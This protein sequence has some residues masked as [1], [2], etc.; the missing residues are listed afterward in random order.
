MAC[1][2]RMGILNGGFMNRK[3]KIIFITLLFFCFKNAAY[4]ENFIGGNFSLSTGAVY[5]TSDWDSA[6]DVKVDTLANGGPF[7]YVLGYTYPDYYV[8]KYDKDGIFKSSATLPGGPNSNIY[9]SKI[10]IISPNIYAEGSL[11]NSLSQRQEIFFARYLDSNNNLILT[12][13]STYSSTSDSLYPNDF[14]SDGKNLYTCFSTNTF[15]IVKLDDHLNI[16]NVFHDSASSYSYCYKLAFDD[17]SNIYISG[18]KDGFN[19]LAKYDKN[20]NLLNSYNIVSSSYSANNIAANPVNGD[21]FVVSSLPIWDTVTQTW[22]SSNIIL[23]KYSSNF[24]QYLSTTFSNPGYLWVKSIV[25]DSNNV[26]VLALLNNNS[27]YDYGVFVFKASDL[28]FKNS[29]FMD[30][31]GSDYPVAMDKDNSGNIYVTGNSERYHGY[32]KNSDIA[33][34]R[35]NPS[36]TSNNPPVLMW[37][38]TADYWF[39][40]LNPESGVSKDIFNFKVKYIDADGDSPSYVKLHLYKDNIEING[41]PFDM[42]CTG[43]D[44]RFG[45]ICEKSIS[46][47]AIGNYS[48]SFEAMDNSDKATGYPTNTNYGPNVS[49]GFI[50]NTNLPQGASYSDGNWIDPKAISIYSSAEGDYVYGLSNSNG[51]PFIIRFSTS[52][53]SI[54]ISTKIHSNSNY[55]YYSEPNDIITDKD[56]NVYISEY[57]S[58]ESKLKIKKIDKNLTSILSQGEFGSSNYLSLKSMVMDE[59]SNLYVLAG[60]YSMSSGYNDMKLI[61][62]DSS[63]SASDLGNYSAKANMPNLNLYPSDISIST[64]SGNIFILGYY[65]SNLDYKNKL[66]LS[67]ADYSFNISST[68]ILNYPGNSGYI[69]PKSIDLDKD[70]N[71]FITAQVNNGMENNILLL[72]YDSNLNLINS[73]M[74]N[75][76]SWEDVSSLAID[77]KTGDIYISGMSSIQNLNYTPINKL[78]A[79]KYDNNLVF[80]S[81]FTYGLDY[82]EI[83]Y[84]S[85]IALNSSGAP[86]VFGYKDIWGTYSLR[87]I[88]A[89]K[90]NL[91]ERKNNISINVK[92]KANLPLKDIEVSLIPFNSG[93]PDLSYIEYGKTDGNGN[94]AIKALSGINYF[95][96]LS[97]PDY[98]PTIKD[99]LL[100]PYGNFNKIFSSDTALSYILKSVSAKNKVRIKVNNIYTG[101]YIMGEIY[102]TQTR[103]RVSYGIWKATDSSNTFEIYNVPN[104]TGGTY[105]IDISIPGW[106][107]TSIYPMDSIPNNSVF[108]VD[109]SSSMA[110]TSNYTSNVS[111]SSVYFSGFIKDN[112]GNSINGAKVSLYNHCDWAGCD[113]SQEVYSDSSG[114][115]SFS[116]LT[117]STNTLYLSIYKIGYLQSKSMVSIPSLNVSYSLE[118]ATYSLRGYIKYG[119]SPMSYTK[120]RINASSQCYNNNDSYGN[121]VSGAQIGDVIAYTDGDG[122][123]NIE[124]LPDGNL[125]ISIEDRFFY[126]NINSG[127]NSQSSDDDIRITISSSGA[128]SPS[129]PANNPCSPGRVWI[130]DSS[131][132][133]KGV[134]PY[135][136]NIGTQISTNAVVS[137]NI[138]FTTT[139]NVSALSPL[140]IDKSSAVIVG[141][142]EDC[143]SISEDKKLIKS[144]CYNNRKMFFKYIYGSYSSNSLDYSIHV[145]SF[146]PVYNYYP[147]YWL[148]IMS[149]MWAKLNSFDNNFDFTLTTSVIRNINLVPSGRL[150]GYLKNPDGSFFKPIGDKS[151]NLKIRGKN[152]SY[153]D[154]TSI[155]QEGY[156]EFSNIPPGKYDISVEVST[157][158]G[159]A[160]IKYEDVIVNTGKTTTLNLSFKKGFYVQPQIYGLPE[161]STPSWSYTII[162]V[163]SGQVMNQ[164]YITELFFEDPRYSFDYDFTTSKWSTAVMEEGQYDFYL[165]LASKYCTSTD[166]DCPG[167]NFNQFANFIGR[168][169]NISI[170]KDSS[171]AN[172]GT[173]SQPIPINIVGSIGQEYMSGSVKGDKIFTDD[174]YE[175]LFA[176]FDSE[177]MPLI[178]AVMIYDNSGELRAF[179]HVLP[180]K[181][182]IVVFENAI[183]EK[184]KNNI[185]NLI[186]NGGMKYYLWGIAPGKYT[187]VFANPNYPPITKI[188][189]LPND[190]DYPFNFDD[191]KF[192]VG[193]VSGVVKSSTTESTPLRNASVYLSGKTIQ[194]YMVTDSSGIFRIDNLPSGSY[195]VEIYMDGFVKT[196]KK[197]NI[198]KDE[199]LKLPDFY[200]EPSTFTITGRVLLS[201]FPS[202]QTK[203][204]IKV[205]AYDETLNTQKP[206][207][208]LPTVYDLTDEN[209]YFT[210]KGVVVGHNYK[211]SVIEPEKM[212]FSTMTEVSQ[213]ENNLGDIVLLDL[214]P[215][216]VVKLRR[217]P[218]SPRKVDVIIYSPRELVNVPTCKYNP[219]VDLDTNT[220]VSL[221]LVPG[222]N[223]SYLGQFTTS[224]NSRY[225]SVNVSVGDITKVEKTVVYDRVSNSKTEQYVQDIGLI[226]G[227][228]QMDQEK[229]EYSGIDLDPGSLTQTSTAQIQLDDLVGGFFRALPSVRTIKTNREDIAISDAIKK[230]M[231]SEIYNIDLA[232]AQTNKSITL[233]L[234]YDKEKVVNTDNLKIYQYVNGEWKEVPG[235]YTID[236]MLGTVSVDIDGIESAYES[237]DSGSTPLSRK[238]HKM[239]AI[240]P[241]GYY[242]ASADS[243]SQSAQFAVFSAKPDPKVKY[244]GS[245]YEAYNMP[246]PFNLKDKT[247]T[248][249]E[250]TGAFDGSSNYANGSYTT[251]GTLIKYHIPSGKNGN[252][253]FVIYNT[254]GEKVRTLDEGYRNGGY[255]YY[256]E[257]DGK[258][259]KNEDCAS[260]VYFLMSYMDGDKL[261]KPH[262]MAII[263]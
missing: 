203:E 187:A 197:F 53:T 59:N 119:D 83:N 75:A 28:S 4:S 80:K 5:G 112:Q 16:T 232:N 54:S 44:A 224:E 77:K 102:L 247:I 246:N 26:Y 192:A 96:A 91:E 205:Y 257:W 73:S 181:D 79:L 19:I 117:I 66:I 72:K 86:Y 178:P 191:Q 174:D 108:N 49:E 185:K 217:N 241:K 198:F 63:F 250:G 123:F 113:F 94:I 182:A 221:A 45:L 105:G 13:S 195:R 137:G 6:Y 253:K 56:G 101:S 252:L 207:E 52:S 160:P 200:L 18:Y 116:G 206:K 29:F 163:P 230:I 153:D 99:Q 183:R 107:S 240:S 68:V 263:K 85:A 165:L 229:E 84:G 220:A 231:A 189:S 3:L 88:I 87:K 36:S 98:S 111:S 170:K 143:D 31:G 212:T 37:L 71:I 2:Y 138:I 20:F 249:I 215:Q 133:C 120:L 251:R 131:G 210:I 156:F 258:N 76:G 127:N 254:A 89:I 128:I 150:N 227:S 235:S 199:E 223:N 126:K 226:G 25:S 109:M 145:S 106:L 24:T 30:A 208:Y 193:S 168:V 32:I 55:Y 188:I 135:V 202:P 219:G 139:Y 201:K 74:Y 216:I 161:I 132:T 90:P 245:S 64:K 60:S 124:G 176:N 243:S 58:S 38:S 51:S 157:E 47:L 11:Y 34:V 196:G 7:I 142:F 125:D 61:K 81:S 15:T 211:V 146:D 67:K 1:G 164:K 218:D 148:N 155:N 104:L 57:V 65:N 43:A 144:N 70:D 158:I 233:N 152:I 35:Y 62:F 14:V 141:I 259:D 17:S 134:M 39:D 236:P 204:G 21:V 179:S 242:V 173:A 171:N 237:S 234:K 129:S 22:N 93:K 42:T 33:T 48:Y 175:R 159:Y 261:G 121:F 248:N 41:S 151:I 256:S 214:P 82:N 190:K 122:M 239:S 228:I 180:D 118:K 103:E 149:N 225:Y 169:K 27:S 262:K 172:L 95:I 130:L 40:G 140:I 9:Y 10:A 114:K 166:S 213:G 154:G 50:G 184:N 222:A 244:D 115:F 167:V 12:S 136:F 177:I 23:K 194:K 186:S 69:N 78:L 238:K 260:G 255:T 8:L 147:K 100:D 162:A 97:T 46:D 209:G 92:D 110:P